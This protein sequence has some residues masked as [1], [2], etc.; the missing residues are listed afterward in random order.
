MRVM[1]ELDLVHDVAPVQLAL[2]LLIPAGSRLLELEEI[3]R[4][5]D[6]FQPDA[7]GYK[8][9]HQDPSLDTLAE[10]LLHLVDFE[11]KREA[12]RAECFAAIWAEVSGGKPA[13]VLAPKGGRAPQLSE[14]WFCCAEPMQD[15][16]TLV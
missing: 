15:R 4:M 9:R 8:W 16:V 11:Q 10:R 3:R 13:P 6:L 7:L 5:V 1:A 2:R 14:P 12:S